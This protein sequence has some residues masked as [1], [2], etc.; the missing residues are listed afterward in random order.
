MTADDIYT[1]DGDGDGAFSGD[2]GP[3]TSAQLDLPQGRPPTP[4]GTW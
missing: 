4:L 3:A 2:G 1:I